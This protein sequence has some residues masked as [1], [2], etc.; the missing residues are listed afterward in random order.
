[1]NTVMLDSTLDLFLPSRTGIGVSGGRAG[2]TDKILTAT[3]G[4]E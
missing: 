2:A 4:P 1:M 3:H